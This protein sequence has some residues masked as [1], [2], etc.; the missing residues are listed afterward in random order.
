MAAYPFGVGRQ[1]FAVF[2]SACQAGDIT[3]G[4]GS[5]IDYGADNFFLR[6]PVAIAYDF[7]ASP[8]LKG[9]GYG[10]VF[11]KKDCVMAVINHLTIWSQAD[12]KL[13]ILHVCQFGMLY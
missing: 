10:D 5:A 12:K 4:S 7:W 1:A 9:D 13:R 3:D 2:H 6:D 11:L 8:C